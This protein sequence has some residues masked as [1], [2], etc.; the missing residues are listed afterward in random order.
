MMRNHI[1]KFDLSMGVLLTRDVIA[2]R[3]MSMDLLYNY[4]SHDNNQWL[5]IRDYTRFKLKFLFSARVWY[6]I[7]KN[8]GSIS[9]SSQRL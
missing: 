5:K 6:C 1:I 3:C 9:C 4:N 7:H 2:T 8:T